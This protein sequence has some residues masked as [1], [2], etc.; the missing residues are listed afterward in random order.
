MSK[1]SAFLRRPDYHGQHNIAQYRQFAQQQRSAG[2][3]N[4]ATLWLYRQCWRKSG[5]LE[6]YLHYLAFRRDLGYILTRLQKKR[7]NNWFN[8]S[9]K[10]GLWIVLNR[11]ANRLRLRL[12]NSTI[13]KQ[14]NLIQQFHTWLKRHTYIQLVGNS[15]NLQHQIQGMAIDQAPLVVRFNRCFSEHTLNA[16]TGVK[17]SIWVCAPDFKHH[18]TLAEWCILTGPDMG[19]WIQ[20][21]PDCIKNHQQVLSVPLAV[22]KELVRMLAAPPSAGI[23][24]TY[25]LYTLHPEC[26]RFLTGFGFQSSSQQYHIADPHHNAV[27]RHNWQQEK[28]LFLQWQ[29]LNIITAGTKENAN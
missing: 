4:V 29:H 14:E 10:F 1:Q 12:L 22:W 27:S 28:A 23:L 25:W 11:H 15:A 2:Y 17:T 21:L 7:I 18:A 20:N 26:Q 8:S 16:D 19:N 13:A 24:V 5:K 6:D 3:Y 9:I